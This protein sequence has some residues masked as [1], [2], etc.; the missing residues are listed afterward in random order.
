MYV[1]AVPFGLMDDQNAAIALQKPNGITGD[2]RVVV[3]PV[4]FAHVGI[5]KVDQSGVCAKAFSHAGPGFVDIEFDQP[6]GADAW[7]MR[8]RNRR[9]VRLRQ[10]KMPVLSK[11]GVHTGTLVEVC[12]AFDFHGAAAPL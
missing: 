2:I 6:N 11:Q 10:V 1:E 3:L 8:Y 5:F 7:K 9:S 4:H 12:D